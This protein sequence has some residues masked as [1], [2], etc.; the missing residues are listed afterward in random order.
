MSTGSM[1]KKPMITR[2]KFGFSDEHRVLVYSDASQPSHPYFD[3]ASAFTATILC[4]RVHIIS[5]PWHKTPFPCLPLSNEFSRV[6]DPSHHIHT[7]LMHSSL[8][9]FAKILMK[10]F[11]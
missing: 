4:Y 8:N 10:G 11:W 2:K 9:K 3:V 5:E 7:D 6:P 1:R